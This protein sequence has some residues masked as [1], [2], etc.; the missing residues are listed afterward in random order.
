MEES[1]SREKVLKKVRHALIYKTD[2]P[3][4]HVDF[5]SPVYK[6]MGDTPD[7]N[8]AQEFTKVGGVFIYCENEA[9]LQQPCRPSILSVTGR[10]FIVPNP[11]CNTYLPRQVYLSIR[12]KKVCS[13]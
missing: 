4:P 3:F 2:N 5:D 1:T 12:T 9:K 8:F 10:I 13:S 11:N 7:V 6:P